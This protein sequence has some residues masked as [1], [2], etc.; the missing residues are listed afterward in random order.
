M[1]IHCPQSGNGTNRIAS[2]LP[3]VVVAGGVGREGAGNS[4]GSHPKGHIL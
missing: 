1:E 2:H 4:W 3:N